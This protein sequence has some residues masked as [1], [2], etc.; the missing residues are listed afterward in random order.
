MPPPGG[1]PGGKALQTR[2]H[3]E[4]VGSSDRLNRPAVARS[5]EGSSAARFRIEVRWVGACTH[6]WFPM[7]TE[8]L[9]VVALLGVLALL[10]I[11][12][13]EDD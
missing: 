9:I 7:L 3:R 5:P 8:V 12:T 1:I 2:R 10:M 11:G 6:R 4:A 13:F